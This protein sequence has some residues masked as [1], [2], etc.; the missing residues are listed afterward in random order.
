MKLP[1]RRSMDRNIPGVLLGWHGPY[2]AHLETQSLFALDFL[3][4]QHPPPLAQLAGA[5]NSATD[6]SPPAQVLPYQFD[7]AATA[8]PMRE[9]AAQ[10]P[11]RRGCLFD[12]GGVHR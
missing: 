3:A 1:N 11:C 4:V 9:A 7:A 10:E 6:L 12:G 2:P 5:S 8:S